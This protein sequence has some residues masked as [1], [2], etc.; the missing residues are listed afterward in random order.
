M[1]LFTHNRPDIN[2][3]FVCVKDRNKGI[4]PPPFFETVLKSNL[5][6]PQTNS[7]EHI[8]TLLTFTFVG[9]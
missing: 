2:C 8:Y 6:M 7:N 5:G 1:L 4:A 9:T 3:S